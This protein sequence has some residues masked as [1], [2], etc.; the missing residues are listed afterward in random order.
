MGV[1]TIDEG[2]IETKD[3]DFEEKVADVIREHFEDEFPDEA[4]EILIQYVELC[5][6]DLD[7]IEWHA[8]KYVGEDEED[9]GP[10]HRYRGP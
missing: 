5:S 2:V 1:R 3:P 8:V 9:D 4:D 6:M 10:D 7:T